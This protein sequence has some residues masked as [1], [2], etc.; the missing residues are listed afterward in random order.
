[1]KVTNR[2]DI[3]H[4]DEMSSNVLEVVVA[5]VVAVVKDDDNNIF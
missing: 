5:V 3:K 1:M 4:N 2:I